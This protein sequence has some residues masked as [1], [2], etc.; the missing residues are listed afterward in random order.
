MKKNPLVSIIMNC[1]NG[2]LFL[3]QSLKSVF[4]QSYKNW[5][6][7]FWDNKSKDQS[8]NILGKFKDKR[9]KYFYSKKFNSL[10]NSRNLAIKK[11]K[12]KYIAFLD[13]DDF[14]HKE[15]LNHQVNFIIKNNL[16]VCCTNFLILSQKN[17]KKIKFIKKNKKKLTTQNLLKRYEVGILTV[18]IEKSL[19]TKNPFNKKYEIIGDFDFFILLSLNYEIGFLNRILATYRLHDIN[20]SKKKIDLYIKEL[21]S[22]IKSNKE[23]LE[24]KNLNINVQKFNLLKLKIKKILRF[25]KVLA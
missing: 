12:G 6:L 23:N 2:E 18:I 19:L 3:E 15:K 9:V 17:N 8:K 4:L 21:S 13:T 7:I 22:W 25:L 11:A 20:L 16:K 1:H 24:N 10:Y 5:E 14:W